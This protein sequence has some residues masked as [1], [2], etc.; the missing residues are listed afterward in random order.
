MPSLATTWKSALLLLPSFTTASPDG[1]TSGI[2][3]TVRYGLLMLRTSK[4][5][6]PFRISCIFAN[7]YAEDIRVG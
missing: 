6:F 7:R 5:Q 2:A 1:Q 4:D 3:V